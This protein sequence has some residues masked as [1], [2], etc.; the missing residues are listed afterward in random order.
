MFQPID[1]YEENIQENNP[2]L[3]KMIKLL[4]VKDVK[5]DKTVV[6]KG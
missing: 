6:N 3:S 2:L 4:T 1:T 5:N